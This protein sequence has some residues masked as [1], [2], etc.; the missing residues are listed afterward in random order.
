MN[1]QKLLYQNVLWRGLFY[2]VTFILNIAIARHFESGLTG[3]LY[4]LVNVYALITL[5]T[6]VSLEAGIIYFASSQKISRASLFMFSIVWV[7]MMTFV[8]IVL[9]VLF[10]LLHVAGITSRVFLY[11]LMF[12][13]GNLFITF[14]NSLYYSKSKF[15]LPNVT[16][17][18]INCLLIALIFFVDNAHWL[19]NG[20]YFS[21]YF[22]SFLL[23][24]LILIC[25]FFINPGENLQLRL[26]SVSELKILFHYCLLTFASNVITFL[27]YRVDYWFVHHYRSAE[28]LGNYI[29]V[30]KI[31]Q[32]FFVL[33][34]ILASAVFPLT[35][36]GYR[37]EI[38]DLLKIVS[39]FIFFLYG[40]LCLFLA[41]VGR[42]L[43]PFVF[44]NS[45][46]KMYIPFLFLIPGLLALSTLYSLTAYY[47]GKNRVMVNVKGSCVALIIII[48]GDA[49]LIPSYGITAA[50]A[51]SSV[52]YIAYHI[53][54]LSVFTKE[55]K[56]SI[57]GFYFF[58][59]SDL[60]RIKKSILKNIN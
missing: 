9:F 43:F 50:A 2:L 20:K 19:T 21:L 53:F 40:I 39:R 15:I 1:I 22:A 7:M 30:S 25:L 4:Y 23:Q 41:L 37:Q 31:T 24:G 44:G 33:P 57:H 6:S 56:T 10:T 3:T 45:F 55:Y 51:V 58:K 52:G 12:I 49:L 34:A 17:I 18:I 11:A 42:W 14:L 60:S 28:D 26:P 29:Q 47:A 38:N 35:A 46:N 8:M 5:V 48:T 59:F 32:M 16:G 13:S 36:S 27:F 54:V